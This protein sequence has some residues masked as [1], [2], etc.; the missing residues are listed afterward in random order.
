MILRLSPQ[1]RRGPVIIPID[2]RPQDSHEK[3][4]TALLGTVNRYFLGPADHLW[5]QVDSGG[6]YHGRIRFSRM[7]GWPKKKEVSQ[8]YKLE[9][10]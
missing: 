9:V 2:L 10:L 8:D 4:K 7:R 3:M 6:V 5:E 1:S